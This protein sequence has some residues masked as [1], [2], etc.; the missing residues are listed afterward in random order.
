MTS[1]GYAPIMNQC[2]GRL[3]EQL[4]ASVASGE[5]VD[6]H[7]LAGAMTLEAIG[8]AAFGLVPQRFPSG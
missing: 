3:V 7:A 8:M 6:V 5:A 4:D 1:Q 2:V